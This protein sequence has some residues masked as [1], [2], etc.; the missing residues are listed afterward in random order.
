MF[1]DGGDLKYNSKLLVR[2]GEW[3]TQTESEPL[4]HQDRDVLD[5][6]QHPEFYAKAVYNNIAL[7]FVDTP[8]VLDSHVDTICLPRYQEN[9]DNRKEC[10][11][12][13]KY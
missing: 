12:K 1:R 3:D 8:F 5:A 2:C 6:V 4:K 10:F 7:L 11:V 13:V 9:F